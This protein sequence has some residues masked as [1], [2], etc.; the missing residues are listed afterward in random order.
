MNETYSDQ[1]FDS[2]LEEM[3]SGE[4]PPDLTAQIEAAWKLEKSQESSS[5][6]S[7][8]DDSAPKHVQTESSLSSPLVV[9]E[10]ISPSVFDATTPARPAIPPRVGAKRSM[11]SEVKHEPIAISTPTGHPIISRRRRTLAVVLAITAAVLLAYLGTQQLEFGSENSNKLESLVAS[12]RDAGAVVDSG[13]KIGSGDLARVDSHE[14]LELSQREEVPAPNAGGTEELDLADLPFA[15]NSRQPTGARSERGEA[16]RPADVKLSSREIVNEVN[17]QMQQIWASV[18]VVPNDRLSDEE[19]AAK[20]YQTLTGTR[21][22]NGLV[23]DALE[24]AETESTGFDQRRWAERVASLEP[25]KTAQTQGR[26]AA[27]S[28]SKPSF[29]N[30]WASQITN[31]LLR[32]SSVSPQSDEAN[33]LTQTFARTIAASES[34]KS[35]PVAL[36]G[37]SLEKQSGAASAFVAALGG[38]GNHRL[39]KRLGTNFLNINLGCARCHDAKQL[40]HRRGEQVASR[41]AQPADTQQAYWALIAL[42]NGI[43]VQ[44]DTNEDDLA[45]VGPRRRVIDRQLDLFSS[46]R[47]PTVFYDL[48]DGR[49]QAAEPRLPGGWDWSEYLATLADE[50]ASTESIQM[51]R[52]PRNALAQ[53][54]S[55]SDVIDRSTVNQTWK[56]LFGRHLVPQ[57]GGIDL[58][59]TQARSDLLDF[60]AGQFGAHNGDLKLLV[61]WLAGSDAFARQP[62]SIAKTAWVESSEDRVAEMQLADLVFATGGH[63]S[64][65]PSRSSLDRS[66]AA[67]VKWSSSSDA[68]ESRRFMLAQPT[69]RP[70]TASQL[71]KIESDSQESD[72]L[73]GSQLSYA[74]HAEQPS[75]MAQN[76]V[77]RILKSQRLSWQQRVEHVVAISEYEVATA[78]V[79]QLANEL[80]QLNAGD[81]EAALLDLF[82]AVTHSDSI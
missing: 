51:A 61:G 5:N 41:F 1:I 21:A 39:V 77:K 25:T 63:Q 45:T 34:W 16:S 71:S 37:G 13:S 46:K 9:A 3:L 15:A 38:G 50:Q 29:S 12:D 27:A 43:D 66:L 7:A 82:W 6:G 42:L 75:V 19:L 59:A 11:M 67:V 10:L 62:S 60:L 49:L 23:Q 53:W 55:E 36:L 2:L 57:V 32:R 68:L 33:S 73:T 54:L 47:T 44:S 20:I 14:R 58:A 70:I 22:P 64:E 69:S 18:G 56:L 26:N 30:Y 76:F 31:Q 4:S 65:L 24:S 78:R 35:I 81:A 72:L 28:F 8:T 74:L 80:L 52:V 48:M 17:A 79:Q 40:Q